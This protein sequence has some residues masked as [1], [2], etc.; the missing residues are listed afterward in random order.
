MYAAGLIISIKISKS[1]QNLIK[2]SKS[3]QYLSLFKM[4]SLGRARG[5]P[6][7]SYSDAVKVVVD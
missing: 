7:A 1:H 6:G 2:N 4:S 3:R 5:Q